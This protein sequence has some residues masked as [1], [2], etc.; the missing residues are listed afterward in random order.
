MK[1]YQRKLTYEEK[2]Y[3]LAGG[4]RGSGSKLCSPM[5]WASFEHNTS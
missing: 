4:F 2:R 5:L 3:I 1:K